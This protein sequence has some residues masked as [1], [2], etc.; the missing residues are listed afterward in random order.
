MNSRYLNNID[1]NV[2]IQPGQIEYQLVQNNIQTLLRAELIAQEEVYSIM[3]QYYNLP[4]EFSNTGTWSYSATYSVAQRV[5]L[6]YATFSSAATY[7]LGECV[8]VPNLNNYDNSDYNLVGEAYMCTDS[9]IGAT[10]STPDMLPNS[11]ADLGNQ[12]G[13][14]NVT[15]PAPLFN[16]LLYYQMGD[17]VYYSG[18]TWSAVISTPVGSQTWADQFVTIGAVPRNVFPTDLANAQQTYWS[19]S[20]VTYSVPAGTL[21]TDTNYWSS[22]D[23]RSQLLLTHYIDVVLYY[24][25]KNIQPTNIPELRKDGYKNALKYFEDLAFGRR[26]SPL[27]PIQP[28]QGMSIRFGGNV[29]KGGTI[30]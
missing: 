20:G 9:S 11:W 22:G 25:H 29:L 27:V 3:N 2:V 19:T 1:Y 24:L 21:P 6:D 28:Q 13:F 5:V 8:I 14:Y 23:N 26:N 12:Y 16:G 10:T 18:L 7:S 30:W 17:V 4:L 15:Y